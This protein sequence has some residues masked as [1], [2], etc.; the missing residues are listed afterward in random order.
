MKNF[1]QRR[2]DSMG[3]EI[4][5]TYALEADE[6]RRKGEPTTP[7]PSTTQQRIHDKKAAEVDT[8]EVNTVLNLE[9]MDSTDNRTEITANSSQNDRTYGK[10]L[11]LSENPQSESHIAG[12]DITV[13]NNLLAA[14]EQFH[15]NVFPL[16]EE[17][18]V[19]P[20][21]DSLRRVGRYLELKNM[22]E[23]VAY[24][25]IHLVKYDHDDYIQYLRKNFLSETQRA[26]ERLKH[27]IEPDTKS[28]AGTK[29]YSEKLS[30]VTEPHELPEIDDFQQQAQ[31]HRPFQ[32]DQCPRSF[33][34]NYDLK[35]H[36][37]IPLP[38][39]RIVD[40]EILKTE[41]LFDV[42]VQESD[43][44]SEHHR[45]PKSIT[46][47]TPRSNSPASITSEKRKGKEKVIE[48]EIISLKCECCPTNS[49]TFQSQEELKYVCP[50]YC[51]Y[52]DFT[53]K[54]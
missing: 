34:R 28:L 6:K 30:A 49:K 38:V 40:T 48:S 46:A 10:D 15:T 36:K 37:Q 5:E 4:W 3:M 1:Y 52:S 45:R 41:D 43:W 23:D 14:S 33:N 9:G 54:C 8:A 50:Q 13:F 39:K 27:V 25:E 7:L 53:N 11:S 51:L 29:P 17:F 2:V 21:K 47:R 26:I 24:A 22:I 42:S 20:P 32:C 12:A 19:T 31:D 44:M 16:C 18:I 35:R